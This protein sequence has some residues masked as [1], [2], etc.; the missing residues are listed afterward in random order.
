L[1]GFGAFQ[2]D[3]GVHRDFKLRDNLALQFRAE[4]FNVL[5]HPNF[6][7]PIGDLNSPTSLNPQF[8][9]SQATLAQ[10]LSGAASAQSAG[11]GAFSSLYQIGGPRSIQLALK[12]KF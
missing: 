9:Q 5:N 8:G 4:L 2:W 1:R 7:P 10:S 12:L 3:L 11:S 6:G